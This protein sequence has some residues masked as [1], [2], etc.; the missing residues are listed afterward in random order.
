MTLIVQD[1]VEVESVVRAC[2]G[3]ASLCRTI[4]GVIAIIYENTSN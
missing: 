2:L 1:G 3:I 4:I